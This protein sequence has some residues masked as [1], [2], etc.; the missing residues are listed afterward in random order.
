MLRTSLSSNGSIAHHLVVKIA[1]QVVNRP[2]VAFQLTLFQ[3]AT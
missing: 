3:A 1:L 2:T